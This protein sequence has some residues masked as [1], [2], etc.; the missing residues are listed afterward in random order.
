MPNMHMLQQLYAY[1][2]LYQQSINAGPEHVEAF[3][4]T[5]NEMNVSIALLFEGDFDR[6]S[7]RADAIK[8]RIERAKEHRHNKIKPTALKTGS[9]DEIIISC[10]ML[11]KNEALTV[12]DSIL[13]IYNAV[14]EIVVLDTGS[15]DGSQAIVSK[16]PKVRLIE[17]EILPWRF[18]TARNKSLVAC[19]GEIA[20]YIDADEVCST[21]AGIV[22]QTLLENRGH[23]RCVGN[24]IT[25]MMGNTWHYN[26]LTTEPRSF[27]LD[28][29]IHFVNAVH[30][31]LSV[32]KEKYDT[33]G[34]DIQYWHFVAEDPEKEGRRRE[35]TADLLVRE[36]KAAVDRPND[37][38]PY[39]MCAKLSASCGDLSEA[40]K[41][42]NA[43][44]D[45]YNALES[46]SRKRFGEYLLLGAHLAFGL[47]EKTNDI[48]EQGELLKTAIRYAG[49]HQALFGECADN[50]FYAHVVFCDNDPRMA[51]EY[52]DKYLELIVAECKRPL[53]L[54][55]T[56]RYYD[57]LM[58][59]RDLLE[60]VLV[61]S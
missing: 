40:L 43:G 2:T 6:R 5:L 18:D 42:C 61:S 46:Y 47:K 19:K 54:Q 3:M 4:A 45:I 55:H 10:P 24:I 34:T 51:M 25:K 49:K 37:F 13:S 56:L 60:Y 35:R 1:H 8:G 30:N 59:R 38:R 17:E 14:D 26:T 57:D 12:E 23:I 36:R 39:Y 29:N 41:W 52:I 33:D 28:G 9:P 22:R 11:V 50:C 27:P 7:K 32:G 31:E 20:L 21:D 53:W 16:Y 48:E 58:L 15:T 44:I